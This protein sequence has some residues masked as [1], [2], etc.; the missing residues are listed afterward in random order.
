MHTTKIRT[1]LGVAAVALVALAFAT[2][3]HAIG[4]TAGTA[5]TNQATVNYRDA[6]NN[7]LTALSNIVSTTVSQ[8]AGV[9]VTPNNTRN[10]TPSDVIYYAHVVTNTGNGND[11]INLTA[12][13]S[14]GWTFQF[15]RDVNNNGTYEAGTDTVLTDS[16]ADGIPDTGLIANDATFRILVAVTVPNNAANGA[17]D[18]TTVTGRSVFNSAVTGTATDTTTVQAPVLGVV[19]SVSPTGNQPPNT[20]LT[21]TIVVTNNGAGSASSVVM[22]DPI[23]TNTAY[24]TGSITYN[25]AARGDGTA[26]GDNADY[27]LTNP[28]KV[29]VSVGTLAPAASATMTFQ[30]RIN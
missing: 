27:N 28:G 30:V 9:T 19:K 16:N 6:N 10:A 17:V 1:L 25:G 2:P 11:R 4:T 20:V 15:Y 14:L 24:V 12:A 3:V 23:P 21:Y 7:A 26:D 13:S 29:T 18:V 5:I 22:T 8:V